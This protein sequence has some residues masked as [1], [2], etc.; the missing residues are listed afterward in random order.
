MKQFRRRLEKLE[1]L[2]AKTSPA[3]DAGYDLSKLSDSEL[4]RLEQLHAKAEP[5]GLRMDL[6]RLS[7][8]EMKEFDALCD[9]A[10][11]EGQK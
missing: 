6:S 4:L 11:A 7:D 3:D 8:S 9:K 2:A 10:R 5:S 1:Q